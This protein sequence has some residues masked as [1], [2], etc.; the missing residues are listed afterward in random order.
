[1]AAAELAATAD[2][3]DRADLAA[4]AAAA[5]RLA[6]EQ[7]AAT[8]AAMAKVRAVTAATAARFSVLAD[9]IFLI[10]DLGGLAW[11]PQL[12]LRNVYLSCLSIENESECL[13]G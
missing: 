6:A 9:R 8:A 1:M 4:T 13:S 2:L 3:V 7:L 12:L 5:D 10:P 11:G